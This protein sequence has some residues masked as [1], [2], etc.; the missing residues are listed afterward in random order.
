MHAR[1]I[2]IF[3]GRTMLIKKNAQ[4]AKLQDGQMSKV[5]VRKFLIRSYGIFQLNQVATVVF[6][7]RYCQRYEVAQ[8]WVSR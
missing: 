6:V 3:F 8:R 2:V 5:K 4:H 7:E 1:M